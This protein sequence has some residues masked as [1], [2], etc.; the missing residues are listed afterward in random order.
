[1]AHVKRLAETLRSEGKVAL[2]SDSEAESGDDLVELPAAESPG[3]D[4]RVRVGEAVYNFRAALDYSV[5]VAS[6]GKGQSQFPIESDDER[7]EARKT[8]CLPNGKNIA[9]YLRGVG[10]RECDLIKAV[11]PC[12]GVD[13]TKRLA[14]LSNRDKHRNLVVVDAISG[15]PFRRVDHPALYPSEGLYPSE[16]LFPSDGY[17]E[18]HVETPIDIALTD[19]A[20]VTET[21][22]EIEV[23]V[24]ALLTALEGR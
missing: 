13:W 19:G 24:G 5:H 8:G 9:A 16:D 23:S 15:Q 4:L 1:M 10:K 22:E 3:D 17:V 2:P 11:Q 12:E 18:M 7:F 6:G 14:A 21:L 20:L